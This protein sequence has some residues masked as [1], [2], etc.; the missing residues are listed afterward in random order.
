M[1]NDWISLIRDGGILFIL[2]LASL[3]IHEWAHAWAADRLG[4]PTPD[5]EGRVTLN[6][7]SHLDLLGSLVIPALNIFVLQGTFSLIGWGKPVRVNPSYFRNRVRDHILV[8]LAGPGSNLAVA[9]LA[10]I[11]LRFGAHLPPAAVE[12]LVSLLQVN[13]ALAAFN[14]L[15]I[16]PL[17]GGWILKY[18]VGMS[19]ETFARIGFYM[20]FGML[21]LI[22]LP[23]FRQILGL[24]IQIFL[25][26]F[27]W[28][29]GV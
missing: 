3:T 18:A 19:E 28:V 26:P 13:V 15:P 25:Q 4:D 14:L 5:S 7:T 23:Q 21:L 2:L 27:R 10:A 12:L 22:N 29:I 1:D 17:D 6:P 8:V 20:S 24:W 16:P 9:L 11:A